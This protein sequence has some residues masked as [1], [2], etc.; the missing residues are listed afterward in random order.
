MKIY[1]LLIIMCLL[2]SCKSKP[3]IVNTAS[4]ETK[5]VKTF[6]KATSAAVKVPANDTSETDDMTNQYEDYYIVVADTGTNYYTLRDKMVDLNRSL[7]IA[8]D[9]MDRFYNKAKDLIA[10]PDNY[11]DDIYAGEYYPRRE[12]SQT[13]SL[14]YLDTYKPGSGKKT[15]A[16]VTGIYEDQFSADSALHVINKPESAFAFKAKVYVGCMH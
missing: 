15:I 2:A 6:H 3:S 5:P 14:E 12:P 13:L 9:T 7:G 1:H 4:A 11:D 16:L 8:I 10:L